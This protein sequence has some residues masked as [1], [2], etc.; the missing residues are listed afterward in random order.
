MYTEIEIKDMM[1]D[2][3]WMRKL[4]DEK[5]YEYDSTSIGQYGIESA[6]PKAQGTTGNKVLVR[7]IRNDKDYRKTQELVDK[8]AFIDSYEEYISSDKNYHLLQLIKIGKSVNDIKRI[9]KMGYNKIMHHVDEIVNVYIIQQK[10]SKML[11]D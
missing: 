6:M 7:V 5:V 9:M 11:E 1:F 2:Y 10:R 3:H 8:L 4:V